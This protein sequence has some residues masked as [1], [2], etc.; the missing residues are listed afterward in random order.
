[1]TEVEA[2]ALIERTLPPA[3]ADLWSGRDPSP[4]FDLGGWTKPRTYFASP[5]ALESA[6]PG[7]TGLCPLVERNGEAVTGWLPDGRF[8]EFY[9]EDGRLGDGAIQILGRNYQE[10]VLSL[11]LELEDAGLREDWIEFADVVEFNHT[12]ELVALLDAE[13]IDDDAIAALRDRIAN[14]A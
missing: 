8:V 3:W 6:A 11:L 14:E 12:A 5:A 13:P 4:T 7:L 9:Y 10:F 2:L 1:M